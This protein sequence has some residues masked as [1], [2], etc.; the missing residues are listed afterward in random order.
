MYSAVEPPMKQITMPQVI[1]ILGMAFI[2]MTG[3]VILAVFDKDVGSILQAIT[4]MAVILLGAFGIHQNAKLDQVKDIANGRLTEVIE[5]NKRL[6]D[7]VAALALLVP[8][9]DSS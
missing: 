6:N 2:V 5:D 8:P 9:A 3:V 7:R 4:T 1:L